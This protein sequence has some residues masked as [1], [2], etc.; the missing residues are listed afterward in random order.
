VSSQS[1]PHQHELP[2]REV[3]AVPRRSTPR[4]RPDNLRKIAND[5]DISKRRKFYD[6][7]HDLA[8]RYYIDRI[9]EDDLLHSTVAK[10]VFKRAIV[11]GL[12]FARNIEEIFENRPLFSLWNEP[13]FRCKGYL[14]EF[15]LAL[16]RDELLEQVYYFVI[17]TVYA[18]STLPLPPPSRK[19]RLALRKWAAGHLDF[20]MNELGR[21]ITLIHDAKDGY[22]PCHGLLRALLEEIDSDSLGALAAI[23]RERKARLREESAPN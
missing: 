1:P 2:A 19:K 14:G 5:F 6:L 17:L 23:L 4:H 11:S 22:S 9:I 8:D 21:P 3:F 10:K 7:A 15:A 12:K 18:S 16:K 20:W 13:Y